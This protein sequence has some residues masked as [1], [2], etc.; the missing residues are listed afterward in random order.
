MEIWKDIKGY[1]NKYR[2]SNYGNVKSLPKTKKEKLLNPIK[3]KT[4]YLLIDLSLNGISKKYLVHRLVA[5]A[6]ISNPENKPQVNHI[7]GIKTDNRLENLEWNTC[8]EN[9]K[10]SIKIGLRTAKGI[11]NSQCKLNTNIVLNILNDKRQYKCISLE[12]GISIST[13][14][15]IKRGY[16][17]THVTGL[18]NIKNL[19]L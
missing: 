11:K 18:K 15:D 8:S 17:W 16:S 5:E 12:Y 6:F 19:K 1:E 2:I 10:H 9:Q 4:G 7:N 3:Q 13:I 14:S